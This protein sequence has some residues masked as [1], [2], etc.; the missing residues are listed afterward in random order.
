MLKKYI[1]ALYDAMSDTPQ[2]QKELIIDIQRRGF[3]KQVIDVTLFGAFAGTCCAV[4]SEYS[5]SL[6]DIGDSDRATLSPAEANFLGNQVIQEIGAAGDMLNDYDVLSYLNDIGGNLVSYSPLAGSDFNFYII[7][8]KQINAFALPGGYICVYNGLIFTTQSEAELTSVMSHEIGHVVQHHIFRNIA[9]YNRNQW[10][11]LAGLLAGGLLAAVNPAAA[12]IAIQGGQGMAVQ[13]MLSFSR[14][15]ERE[16]DR[17]GQRIMYQ[18]GFDPN[19]MPLFFERLQNANKF[20]DNGAYEFLRTHPVTTAR[21]SEAENRARGMQVKMRPDSE[22]FLLIR[23][24]CRSRQLLPPGAILFYKQSI[25]TKKYSSL[26]AQYYG[27]AYS[28]FVSQDFTSAAASIAKISGSTFISNPIV[29]SLKA[30]ILMSQKNYKTAD[31]VFGD[32]LSNFPSYKG[33]WLGQVDLYINSK[34]YAKAAGKL[35]N[36]A[37]TY[38]SDVDIWLRQV[39]LYAD[40]GLNNQQKYYY[41]LGNTFFLNA[42]YKSALDQ[43]QKAIAVKKGDATLNDVISAKILDTKGLI[44]YRAQFTS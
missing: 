1:T 20:N 26:D 27:L 38:P 21:I 12:I 8:D 19:A 22:S 35:D 37:Q 31:K 25:A 9:N 34:Q 10:L 7:K 40:T 29:L 23:E 30:Q 41:S 3:L 15:Y 16:A 14:D 5:G 43:Y 6:P 42:D 4:P 39:S 18:A 33:L 28:Y 36:L 11:A 24:K 44:K 13:N 17:V 32:A 2:A